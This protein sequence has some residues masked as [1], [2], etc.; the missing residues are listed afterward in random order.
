M[1][2]A[3]EIS[4]AQEYETL[5]RMEQKLTK[6][7]E[8]R[9]K[10]ETSYQKTLESTTASMLDMK[11]STTAYLNALQTEKERLEA[12]KAAY[13]ADSNKLVE[14]AKSTFGDYWSQYV[15]YDDKTGEITILEGYE[16]LTGSVKEGMDEYI[17]AILEN[18]DQMKD[19]DGSIEE[20]TEAYDEVI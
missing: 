8:S 12:N 13:L 5:W 14:V 7:T 18:S 19:L 11:N 16:N 6:A 10:A 3:E 2:T 4:G 9:E 20:N 1:K 15:S 17:S